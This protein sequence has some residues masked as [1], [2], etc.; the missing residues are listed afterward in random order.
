MSLLKSIQSRI[1]NTP[2]LVH[3]PRIYEII[4]FLSDRISISSSDFTTPFL[5]PDTPTTPSA[6]SQLSAY[7]DNVSVVPIH[8]TLVHRGNL[9]TMSGGLLSYTRIE[10][11]LAS[12]LDD[13]DTNTIVLDIDSPGGEVSGA[14]DLADYIYNSRSIKPIYA[15]I[16]DTGCS[17]AYLLASSASRIYGT[18]TMNVGSIGVRMVLED[19]SEANAKSGIKY[20]TITAGDHKADYSPNHPISES[21]LKRAQASVN[22]VYDLFIATVARNLSV[23]ESL[24]RSTQALVYQGQDAIDIGLVHELVHKNTFMASL[25]PTSTITLIGETNM[26]NEN[27][28]TEIATN[29]THAHAPVLDPTPVLTTDQIQ[30]AVSAETSRCL[31]IVE[32]CTLGNC[33]HMA[34]DLISDKSSPDL[35]RK[36]ILSMRS[37]VTDATHIHSNSAPNSTPISD[38]ALID[39][40]KALS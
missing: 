14:F 19:R 6:N 22:T 20:T 37:A 40:A 30:A 2:L 38:N 21:A 28:K 33:L 15:L 26:A 13:P 4:H 29:H 12:A 3:E 36:M 27:N 18:R 9:S 31:E 25:S 32:A 17:A 10:A 34:Y 24:P 1:I 7:P 39:A 16:N 23:D 5:L 35:A 11:M 8:G